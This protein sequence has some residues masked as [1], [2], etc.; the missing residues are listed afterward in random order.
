MLFAEE[1]EFTPDAARQRRGLRAIL[2]D[3]R[4][5]QIFVARTETRLVATATLLFTV[6]TAEGGRAALLEDVVVLPAYRRKG[7]ASALLQHVLGAARGQGVTRTTLLTD[8]ENVGA[9]ALY[10]TLGFVAS[11]M[12]TMRL[13]LS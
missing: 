13:R 5:G 12:T 8:R 4:V 1:S 3:P 10:R 2:E 11:T 7:V 6:S 9:Q